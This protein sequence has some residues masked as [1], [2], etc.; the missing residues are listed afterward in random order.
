VAT[1]IVNVDKRGNSALGT[2]RLVSEAVRGVVVM[3]EF[4]TAAINAPKRTALQRWIRSEKWRRRS[5]HP[6]QRGY[7]TNGP[8]LE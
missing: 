3:S 1:H 2:Q 6:M 7:D 8:C 4:V 5:H